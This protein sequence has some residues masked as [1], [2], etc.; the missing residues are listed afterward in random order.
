MTARQEAASAPVGSLVP[1][2][3][4]VAGATGSGKSTLARYLATAGGLRRLAASSLLLE[5]AGPGPR[6]GKRERLWSWAADPV[7]ATARRCADVT[8]DRVTDLATL[9]A[10]RETS[11]D[12]VVETAGP[13]ALLQPAATV[14]LLVLLD[15]AAPV[16]AARVQAGLAGMVSVAQAGRLVAAKDA[17][18]VAAV[19]AAWALDLSDPATHGWRF[20]LVIRCPDQA[21]CRHPAEC[22]Q[23][24]RELADAAV[25]VYVHYLAGAPAREPVWRLACVA[26]QWRPW[27]VRLSPALTDATGRHTPHRW[28]HRLGDELT[29]RAHKPSDHMEQSPC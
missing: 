16:R 25:S 11:E 24:V 2:V 4:I 5:T 9:S 6:P 17:A 27:L 29:E 8:A 15:A 26:K 21:V 18:T 1:G 3:V 13:V 23:A 12:V 20:D 7:A 22:R 10:C 14:A 28:R 19:R